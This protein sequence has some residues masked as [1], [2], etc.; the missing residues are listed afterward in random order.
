MIA[1]DPAA[2]A[3]RHAHSGLR[4]RRHQRHQRRLHRERRDQR[5]EHAKRGNDAELREAGIGGRNEGEECERGA[6]GAQRDTGALPHHRV[7]ERFL[8]R[9]PLPR[10]FQMPKAEMRAEIHAEP[11]EQHKER[12][13]D[14]VEAADSD[15]GEAGRPERA[16]DERYE[17]RDNQPP[18]ADPDNEAERH[19]HKGEAA[20]IDGAGKR[21]AQFLLPENR[22]A[23]DAH[24]H[25]GMLR[26]DRFARFVKRIQRGHGAI[27]RRIVEDRHHLDDAARALPIRANAEHG[28]PLHFR[29]PSLGARGNRIGELREHVRS[30]RRGGAF[31]HA[32]SRHAEQRRHAAKGR[33]VGE[34]DEETARLPHLRPDFGDLLGIEEKQSVT[35]EIGR[36]AGNLDPFELLAAGRRGRRQARAPPARPVPASARPR[37]RRPRRAARRAIRS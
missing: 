5:H 19:E 32:R 20:R 18:G 13:G 3:D 29:R 33:I 12:D 7:E 28:I 26:T 27:D 1:F 23:G 15:G 14:E 30:R 25:V 6:D 9:L 8:E 17:Q 4:P 2:D 35:V 11:E 24:R 37:P 22:L 21:V 10:L 16:D 36:R 31:L 34:A